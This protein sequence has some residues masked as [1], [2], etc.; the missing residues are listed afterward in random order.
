MPAATARAKVEAGFF[1]GRPLCDYA[2]TVL[3]HAD[4]PNVSVG[5][6]EDVG[7]INERWK[8]ANVC[9][10]SFHFGMSFVFLPVA[11]LT[12]AGFPATDQGRGLAG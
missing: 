10:Y 4:N 5:Q 2:V 3:V 8:R 6:I 1:A 11:V 12:L 7:Q 9:C